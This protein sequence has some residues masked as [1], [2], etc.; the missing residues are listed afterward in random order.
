MNPD[1][2]AAYSIANWYLAKQ[3]LNEANEYYTKALETTEDA[4]LR[5]NAYIKKAYESCT[6]NI[7]Q[8]NK[9]LLQLRKLNQIKESLTSSR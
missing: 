9:M 2:S 3:Q 8:P 7:V 5:Y 4:E 6:K 1:A